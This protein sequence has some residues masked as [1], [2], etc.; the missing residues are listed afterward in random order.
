MY[1]FYLK[2]DIRDWG[3]SSAIPNSI[4]QRLFIL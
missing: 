1:Q 3:Q 2:N 4:D